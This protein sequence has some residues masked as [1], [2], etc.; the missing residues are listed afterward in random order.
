MGCV[1]GNSLR[2]SWKGMF[3]E[4]FGFYF[5]NDCVLLEDFKVFGKMIL[6]VM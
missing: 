3:G 2:W 6:V 4:E 5:D 1:L